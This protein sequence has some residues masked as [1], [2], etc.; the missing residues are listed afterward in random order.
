VL[1]S[2]G[3]TEGL[4]RPAEEEGGKSGGLPVFYFKTIIKNLSLDG[5]VICGFLALFAAATWM[6]FLRKTMTFWVMEKQNSAFN[7]SFIQEADPMALASRGKKYP[8]SC[9]YQV[10]A[11]GFRELEAHAAVSENPGHKM[12]SVRGMRA[13]NAA[14][15]RAFVIQNKNL[16]SWL[17]FLTMAIAGGPFLGLLGTVW[18]VMNTFAAMAE[19]GEANLAAIAPGVASALATTVFGLI[20]ATP[21]LFAYNYL[22]T[23]VKGLSLDLNTLWMSTR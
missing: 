19:A 16:N 2:E 1:I 7:K 3:P 11:A 15:D 18:S 14:L 8:N 21:A 6:V 9:L 23:K 12:L 20:V 17:I 5:W 22:I 10:Y 13:F 4:I